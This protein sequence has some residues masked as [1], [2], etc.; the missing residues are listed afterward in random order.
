MLLKL[1]SSKTK[2]DLKVEKKRGVAFFPEGNAEKPNNENARSKAKMSQNS[3]FNR[4]RRTV[5]FGEWPQ[6]IKQDNVAITE[7]V[8][9][10]GFFLGNDGNYYAKVSAVPYYKGYLFSN[11]KEIIKNSIYYFKVEP[12]KWTIIT[13]ES[14]RLLI[15][16]DNIIFNKAYQ[17][18]YYT[19][20]DGDIVTD[21]ND[22][23]PDTYASNYC[24]SE[25]REWLLTDFLKIIESTPNLDPRHIK[26]LPYRII[27]ENSSNQL[28]DKAFLLS[29]NEV[30]GYGNG[31]KPH[32]RSAT[33]YAKA[34]GAYVFGAM[35]GVKSRASGKGWW[36]L[37]TP[38]TSEG[39]DTVHAIDQNGVTNYT[40]IWVKGYGIVPALYIEIRE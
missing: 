23:P 38:C 1:F 26:L 8:D 5:R 27:K 35:S 15:H 20:D 30:E 34:C 4:D 3:V 2:G 13:E 33:D 29:K 28:F 21:F 19:D 24:Y 16:C 40:W 14:N 17:S 9:D 37:R 18:D 32:M 6:T 25:I 36:W 31:F 11:Q 12:L 22:A 10:R 39:Q 7:T